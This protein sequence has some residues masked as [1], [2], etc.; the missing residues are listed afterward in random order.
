MSHTPTPWKRSDAP[1]PDDICHG[2]RIVVLLNERNPDTSKLE[3]RLI[4]V[5]ANEWGWECGDGTYD[6]Y[7]PHDG[8][9][10]GQEKDVIAVLNEHAALRAKLAKLVAASKTALA[11]VKDSACMPEDDECIEALSAALDAAREV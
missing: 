9:H 6:G 1:L 10:W 2:D 3:P 5:V 7:E 11:I 4:V 8:T